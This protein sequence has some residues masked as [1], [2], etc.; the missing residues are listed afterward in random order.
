MVSCADAG[1]PRL[2]QIAGWIMS[3]DRALILSDG[4][5]MGLQDHAQLLVLAKVPGL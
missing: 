4:D 2:F 3:F 5:P 1:A